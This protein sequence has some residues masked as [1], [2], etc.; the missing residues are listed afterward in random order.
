MNRERDALPLFGCFLKLTAPGSAKLVVLC[1][2]VICRVAPRP[3][4]PAALFEAVERGEER[5]GFYGER[6]ACDLLDAPRDAQTM[7]TIGSDSPQNRQVAGALREV[8]CAHMRLDRSVIPRARPPAWY[9]KSRATSAGRSTTSSGGTAAKRLRRS[10]P[11]LALSLQPTPQRS[12]RVRTG[13]R[14]RG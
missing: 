3:T 11:R 8:G 13:L 4:H 9:S 7:V 2:P 1:A 12:R 5:S 14:H 10:E 6:A